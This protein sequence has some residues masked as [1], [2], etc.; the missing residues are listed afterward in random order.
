MTNSNSE[1]TLIALLFIGRIAAWII[2]GKMAWNWTNPESF[3]GAVGF[4][5]AWAFIGKFVDF[6]A[7][8]VCAVSA[9]GVK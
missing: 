4:L 7:A 3:W 8:A 5:M 9:E 6:V 2:S 1:G